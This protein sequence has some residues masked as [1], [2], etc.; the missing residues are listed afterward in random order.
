MSTSSTDRNASCRWRRRRKSSAVLCAI[1]NSQPSGLPIGAGGGIR[2]HRLD[3]RILQHVLA[4][5]DRADHARAVAMQSWT[6]RDQQ[7][8][9]VDGGGR[10]LR[11]HCHS[12]SGTQVSCFA[13]HTV[14]ADDGSAL[15]PA[16]VRRN[17][18]E[19]RSG[20]L[21]GRQFRQRAGA[22]IG[23]GLDEM[24]ERVIFQPQRKI[25]HAVG[26]GRLQFGKHRRDQFGIP[27]GRFRLWSCT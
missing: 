12:A 24:D 2:L 1:R 6:H 3:Q 10:C 19:C 20:R 13:Q 15:R 17:A 4:V 14:V 27:V 18:P 7:A 16:A 22:V 9:D 26:L 23:R 8:L 11:D 21:K 25:A 5:D